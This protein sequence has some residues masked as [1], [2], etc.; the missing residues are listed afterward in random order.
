L[1]TGYIGYPHN[2]ISPDQKESC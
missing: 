1:S 2:F